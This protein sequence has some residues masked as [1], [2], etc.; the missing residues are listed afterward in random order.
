[1][2]I[3]TCCL[4]VDPILGLR[5]NSEGGDSVDD[6]P[7]AAVVGNG[8][9][10]PLVPPLDVDEGRFRDLIIQVVRLGAVDLQFCVGVGDLL[11]LFFK[12]LQRGMT[13]S[14]GLDV[15]RRFNL[16]VHEPFVAHDPDS[17]PHAGRFAAHVA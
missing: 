4:L 12:A 14:Y 6:R 13:G 8:G 1:M 15:F 7:V 3:S 16:V 10:L 9:A 2:A 5:C 17:P 11:P